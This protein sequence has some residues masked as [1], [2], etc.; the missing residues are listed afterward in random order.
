MPTILSHPAVPL[1]ISLGLGSTLIPPRLLVA[2]LIA[3]VLPDADVL[4][5]RLGIAYGHE[6]GHRGLSHS[7]VFAVAVALAASACAP[8]LRARRLTTF[9]FM[10]VATASHG[11]LDMLTDG[12]M[13]VALYWPFSDQRFFFPVQPIH[14]SPLSLRR[15]FA[16]RGA[17]VL[18]SEFF[19]VWLPSLVAGLALFVARRRLVRSG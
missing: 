11:L 8:R 16:P 15:L 14:V 19:W 4:A 7:L 5:F 10:L 13:G 3:S 1:A 12:G 17:S 18:G 6:L 9:L 2:G